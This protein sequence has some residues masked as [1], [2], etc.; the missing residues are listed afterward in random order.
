MTFESSQEELLA[1]FGELREHVR[2]L[3]ELGVE[4]CEPVGATSVPTRD[5]VTMPAKAIISAPE[6]Q[7]PRS[8][9]ALPPPTAGNQ[10]TPA[11]A[12]IESLFGEL[13]PRQDQ[14]LPESSETFAQIWEEIG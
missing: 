13:H 7:Q 11:P 8:I 14:Q 12:M 2:Y 10:P 3:E 6:P 5:D 4:H 1:I 9:K